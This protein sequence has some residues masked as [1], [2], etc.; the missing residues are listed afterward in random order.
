MNNPIIQ[1]LN[2]RQTLNK[3][4]N[5]PDAMFDE[6]YKNN[7]AFKEFAERNKNKTIDQIAGDYGL[8]PD[9]VKMIIS[10]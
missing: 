9:L 1:A 7:P 3:T 4:M 10:K 2:A 8:N 6:L 5:D